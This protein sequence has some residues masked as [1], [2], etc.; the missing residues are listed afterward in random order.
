MGTSAAGELSVAYVAGY[1]R[2]RSTAV[3][4]N[5]GRSRTYLIAGEAHVARG[6]IHPKRMCTCGSF[7]TDCEYWSDIVGTQ[8][9]G[10]SRWGVAILES[11][12]GLFLPRFVLREA[13]K[14]IKALDGT[15]Y[16]QW[17]WGHL[18]R[19][20]ELGFSGVVDISKTT[21]TTA[22]RPLLYSQLGVQVCITMP[23]RDVNAVMH[24][25]RSSLRRRGKKVTPFAVPRTILSRG[26][27]HAMARLAAYR[28][29]VRLDRRY[30]SNHIEL[31]AFTGD[32]LIAGNRMRHSRLGPGA[33]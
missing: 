22:S 25:T 12:F 11:S 27:A 31:S 1:G 4:M 21:R 30:E 2:S 15:T 26:L 23:V 17:L 9:V 24:S 28:C 32:H 19:A 10:R 29:R 3:G 13:M 33:A 18:R 7:V 6:T 20:H 16:N 14:R 8:F 5:I